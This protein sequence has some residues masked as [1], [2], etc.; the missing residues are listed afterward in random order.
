MQAFA[1]LQ[2]N[3]VSAKAGRSALVVAAAAGAYGRVSAARCCCRR[4]GLASWAGANQ[5]PLSAQLWW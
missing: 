2:Q 4:L 5:E 1:P 3:G